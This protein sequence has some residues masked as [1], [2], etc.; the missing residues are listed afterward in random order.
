M[1]DGWSRLAVRNP[2]SLIGMILMTV[3]IVLFFFLFLLDLLG[4]LDNPYLGLVTFVTLPAGS[5]L[6]L[7]LIPIGVFWARRRQRSLRQLW[8]RVDLNEPRHRHI[9]LFVL[10]TTAVNLLLISIAAYGGVHYMES[11]SFC[12]QVCHTVMEPQFVAYQDAPHSRVACVSCHVGAGATH[13]AHA[14]LAGVRQLVAVTTRT[15]ERPIPFPV[16]A[17]RPARDTCE[18][19]HWPDKYHGDQMREFREFGDDEENTESV[20]RMLIHVGG[21]SERLGIASGIHWHMNIANEI[22]YIALDPQRQTI[23]WVRLRDREG[24][25]R[26][27]VVEGTTPED[28]A[29]GE[30]RLMDCMDCHNRPSHT[31]MASAE[32]AVDQAL[33]R[34]LISRELPF[35]RRETVAALKEEYPSQAAAFEAIAARLRAFYRAEYPDRFGADAPAVDRAIAAAQ[36]IY[37]RNVFPSMNVTWGTYPN[38]RGH[39]DSP[40]CFRCHDDEHVAADG[41]V[42]RMDCTICHTMLEDE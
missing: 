40:G 38:E 37:R 3:C 29:A 17:M 20:T 31:F 27:Y 10:A 6:G 33:A 18:Q 21:G 26:E 24:R 7:V 5:A 15:Y 1:V 13:F 23:P 35:V 16:A 28:L 2:I 25:V 34:E 4:F 11:P 8:P 42:I 39:M 9:T 41:S 22:E 36:G 12:G 30:R 19:C 32:R 14:K